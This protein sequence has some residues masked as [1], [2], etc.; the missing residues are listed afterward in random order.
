MEPLPKAEWVGL[1]PLVQFLALLSLVLEEEVG[2]LVEL[3][4]LQVQEGQEAGGQE[5][6]VRLEQERLVE[7]GQLILVQV[8]EAAVELGAALLEERAVLV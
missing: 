5:A 2:E 8:E 1:E 3:L 6:M 7:L 4:L